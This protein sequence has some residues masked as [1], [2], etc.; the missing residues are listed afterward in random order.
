MDGKKT[1]PV[2]ILL[3]SVFVQISEAAAKRGEWNPN[4]QENLTVKIL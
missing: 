4:D 3:I 2:Y 1:L